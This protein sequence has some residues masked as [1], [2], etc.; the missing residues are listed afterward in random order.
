MMTIR[1]VDS[2]EVGEIAG[3]A[4]WGFAPVSTGYG[5]AAGRWAGRLG[6]AGEI[7]GVGHS[8]RTGHP[9]LFPRGAHGVFSAWMSWVTWS[10]TWRLA[11]IC[12]LIFSQAY[13]TVV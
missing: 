13:M 11:G 10:Y 2:G 9:E 4:G 7:A 12:S 5:R 8:L 1:G 6:T 3:Q